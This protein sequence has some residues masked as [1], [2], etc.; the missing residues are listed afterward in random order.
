M[1]WMELLESWEIEVKSCF[2]TQV[3]IF[4]SIWQKCMTVAH[5]KYTEYSNWSQRSFSFK[6][7]LI[8]WITGLDGGCHICNWMICDKRNGNWDLWKHYA[9]MIIIAT[10]TVDKQKHIDNCLWAIQWKLS[11]CMDNQFFLLIAFPFTMQS[12][13]LTSGFHHKLIIVFTETFSSGFM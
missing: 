8:R 3:C 2:P 1:L 13:P 6:E 11:C 12:F 7:F 4:M 10:S 5:G 9:Q